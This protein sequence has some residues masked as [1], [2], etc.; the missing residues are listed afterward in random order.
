M[1]LR[2]S[3]SMMYDRGTNQLGTL[4]SNMLKT[5]MQLSTGRRVLTPADDPVASARALEVTQSLEINDQYKIN[6][7]TALSS[8]AQ[9]DT[10]D[11]GAKAGG[12]GMQ[13]HD[14]L[15]TMGAFGREAVIV[16]RRGAGDK[17][18][19]TAGSFAYGAKLA[20]MSCASHWRPPIDHTDDLLA[21]DA[22]QD[23]HALLVRRSPDQGLRDYPRMCFL[24]AI[25]KK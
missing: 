7:Q 12:Q 25:C 22:R 19:G 21:F 3:T 8:L 13:G 20:W 24:P 4:Q 15:Q 23:P 2:I 16:H 11:L 5:Q 1:S 10:A 9:V 18:R 17:P 6:R 14:G